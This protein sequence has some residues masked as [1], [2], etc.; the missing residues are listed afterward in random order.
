MSRLAGFLLVGTLV[1]GSWPVLADS[2]ETLP[3]GVLRFRVRPM[4]VTFTDRW[5][6]QG[7]AEPVTADIDDTVL[8]NTVFEDLAVLERVYNMPDGTL[9]AGR[10]HVRSRVTLQVLGFALEYGLTS[11]LTVA[12]ILPYVGA[13]NELTDLR[14]DPGNIGRN[15]GDGRISTEDA[16]YL[17]LN[18]DKD[19]TTTF[20]NPLRRDDV[21][22]I[23]RDDFEY[24]WLDDSSA[25]SIGD[26]EVGAKYRFEP[27][28]LWASSVQLGMRAPTGKV[29]DPDDLLAVGIGSGAF[30]FQ[31]AFQND[32][33]PISGLRFNITPSYTWQLPQKREM[34]VPTRHDRPIT[35]P[36]QREEIWLNLGDVIVLDTSVAY[37]P[38]EGLTVFSRYAYVHELEDEVE[39]SLGLSYE[40][41]ETLTDGRNHLVEGG[42][43]YSTVPLMMRGAFPVPLDLTLSFERAVAGRNRAFVTNLLALD[44]AVYFEVFQ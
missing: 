37:T 9:S 11:R 17:P 43:T 34:R 5:N 26:L 23:L 15:P 44:M 3:G 24:R 28:G 8:D 36:D 25:R 19:P 10:S 22:Q 1:L 14:L 42:I 38:V 41:L 18:H 21:R 2:A 6:E 27:V 12:A 32:L 4:H 29:A 30:A 31:G 40:A 39:G 20:L 13:S 35:T 33:I 16:E 7:R